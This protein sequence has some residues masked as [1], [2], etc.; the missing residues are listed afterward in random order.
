MATRIYV[1]CTSDLI[2]GEP[3]NRRTTL[4]NIVCRFQ[5]E[6][7]FDE[8]CDGLHSAGQYMV[9]GT[10]CHFLVDIGPCGAE[11]YQLYWYK[12]DGQNLVRQ[13]ATPPLLGYLK[14]YPFNPSRGKRAY[15]TDHDLKD[16][17]GEED[18]KRLVVNRIEKKRR[19]G[20]DL[21]EADKRFLQDYPDV[22]L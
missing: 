21:S 3:E 20:L 10:R 19:W 11:E 14:N 2:P 22:A 16:R 12:W 18:F 13:T 1:K 7:D 4:A 9:D 15:L 5:L 17:L 8:D 6:R